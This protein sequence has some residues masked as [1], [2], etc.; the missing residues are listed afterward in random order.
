MENESQGGNIALL[1]FKKK[2]SCTSKNETNLGHLKPIKLVI[3]QQ[4]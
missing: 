3:E 2:C 1:T 4:L